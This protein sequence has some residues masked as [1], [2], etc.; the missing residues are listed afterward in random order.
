MCAWP[1][2]IEDGVTFLHRAVP[3]ETEEWKRKRTHQI[4]MD[5]KHKQNATFRHYSECGCAAAIVVVAVAVAVAVVEVRVCY[6][7]HAT[8][9]TRWTNTHTSHTVDTCSLIT[10]YNF[11]AL[12]QTIRARTHA[13]LSF[14]LIGISYAFSLFRIKISI[15]TVHY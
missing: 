13:Q 11:S 1:I 14:I 7:V 5:N 15:I 6:V 12:L 3:F 8:P 9:N 2:G 10:I 4:N